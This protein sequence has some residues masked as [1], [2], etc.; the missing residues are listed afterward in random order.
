MMEALHQRKL[1]V[2]LLELSDQVMAPVDKEMAN[3]LH[4]RI[5][6]RASICACAPASLPSRA[7]RC[8][9]RRPPPWRPPNGVDCA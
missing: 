5:R 1:D 7:W 8:L 4:A 2:T 9:P 3:L 6:G